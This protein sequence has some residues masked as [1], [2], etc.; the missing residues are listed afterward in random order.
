M[1][2][3]APNSESP[4]DQGRNNNEISQY[5]ELNDNKT[6]HIKPYLIGNR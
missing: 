6:L 4:L 1:G 3:R 5:L 2:H